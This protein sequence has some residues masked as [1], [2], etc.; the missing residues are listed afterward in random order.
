MSKFIPENGFHMDPNTEPLPE[1]LQKFD[2]DN[3]WAIWPTIILAVVIYLIHSEIGSQ[4]C[5][6]QNC[7][8]KLQPIFT[9]DDKVQII[10]KINEGLRKNHRSVTWRISF[11]CAVIISL[12]IIALFYKSEMISGIIAF[13]LILI[14]FFTVAACFSWFNAHYYRQISYKEEQTLQELRHKIQ[15]STKPEFDS[16]SNTDHNNNNSNNQ[17]NHDPLFNF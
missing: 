8:N 13:L 7:S 4:G 6:D 3:I 5:K 16:N 2:F 11:I 12:F 9:T 14:V 17:N 15:Q 10:D 1:H